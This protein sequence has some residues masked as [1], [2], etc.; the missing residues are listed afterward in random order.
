M[1]TSHTETSDQGNDAR[2]SKIKGILRRFSKR[3]RGK[4]GEEGAE[5]AGGSETET[6]YRIDGDPVSERQYYHYLL[7]LYQGRNVATARY[8]ADLAL[9][10]EESVEA[11]KPIVAHD[12]MSNLQLYGMVEEA[13]K[14]SIY[15]FHVAV[16]DAIQS[17][18]PPAAEGT[19]EPRGQGPDQQK[20]EEGVADPCQQPAGGALHVE[21]GGEWETDE[22]RR[23]TATAGQSPATRAGLGYEKS[24]S[25]ITRLRRMKLQLAIELTPD[26]HL[27]VRSGVVSRPQAFGLFTREELER[28]IEERLQR[29]IVAGGLDTYGWR[30]HA[31]FKKR[32]R[33]FE[34]WYG[35][36]MIRSP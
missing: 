5:E 15:V 21:N 14:R 25:I 33:F 22:E 10:R 28:R 16:P 23:E 32:Q 6:D 29:W 1:A 11:E 17:C 27:R 7:N 24:P 2:E 26:F 12:R 31:K 18:E 20:E 36:R 9:S 19:P 13:R 34:K 30:F 4:R 8:A 3:G 35:P